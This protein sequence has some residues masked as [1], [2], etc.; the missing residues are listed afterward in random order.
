M[1]QSRLTYTVNV[2]QPYYLL[3]SKCIGTTVKEGD[4]YE[5]GSYEGCGTYD[6]LSEIRLIKEKYHPELSFWIF[7][8]HDHE[9][10]S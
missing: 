2:T 8:T 5:F 6:E 9:P 3:S 10:I 1:Q 4:K 7:R